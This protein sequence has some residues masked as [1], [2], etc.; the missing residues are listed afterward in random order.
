MLKTHTLYKH[1]VRV[2]RLNG[3]NV[4]CNYLVHLWQLQCIKSLE[5]EAALSKTEASLPSQRYVWY[6]RS[7]ASS[8]GFI[9]TFLPCVTV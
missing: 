5:R 9:L 4:K 2:Q 1:L 6:I 7:K 8:K 3:K